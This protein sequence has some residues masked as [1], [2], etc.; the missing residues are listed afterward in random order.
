MLRA[1]HQPVKAGL[2]RHSG[3]AL[4]LRAG[5]MDS[6]L[7]FQA[8]LQYMQAWA[9]IHGHPKADMSGAVDALRGVYGDALGMIPYLTG[10][11]SGDELRNEDRNAAIERYENYRDRLLKKPED[12]DPTQRAPVYEK[13]QPARK[14][15][16][17]PREEVEAPQFVETPK[18]QRR[19]RSLADEEQTTEQK[20][21]P[22]LKRGIELIDPNQTAVGPKMDIYRPE[23]EW[24]PE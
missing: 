15:A 22:A 2:H 5:V 21:E 23:Y 10:G 12:I 19:A 3:V 18:L 6:T 1:V 4:Q 24:R 14:H 13:P 20:A 16:D 11:R 7:R 8:S 9:A 17:R